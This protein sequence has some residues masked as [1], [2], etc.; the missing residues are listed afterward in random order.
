MRSGNELPSSWVHVPLGE[1][2]DWYGGGTPSKANDKFW[3]HGT[4]P[5]FSPKDMKA[6]RLQSSEDR[7]TR[8]A[9]DSSSVDVFPPDTVLMVVRSGILAHTFP[10]A[11]AGV[12]ATMNQDLKGVV[13]KGGIDATYLA[14]ALRSSG[15][16]ILNQCS[17]A[18]TT[19]ASIDTTA[20]H[21]Y[22]IPLAPTN[23]Q[24]RVV[25]KL[26]ELL[27]DLDAGI[28]AL[29]RARANLKRYRAT[30]LKA[31]VEG[32]LTEK[33]RAAHPHAEPAEKLLERILSER[34]KKWEEGQLKKYA[35]KGK[36]LPKKWRDEYVHPERSIKPGLPPLPNNWTYCS[37]A[38]LLP[39]NRSGTR[40]G[41]FGTLLGKHEHQKS[42]VP[43]VGIENISSMQFVAGSKIHISQE[44]AD[45][46]KDYEL[47]SDDVVISRSGTVGEVCVIP[48]GLGEARMSTNLM[49][50]RLVAEGMRPMWFCAL[51]AG[52]PAVATQVHELCSG[53]TR[54]FLNTEI[55]MSIVF[56]LP[57]LDEQDEILRQLES[58]RAGLDR[59]EN[60]FRRMEIVGTRL[61]QA[62]LKRAFEGK[63]V[64]QDPKDE[65]AS[66]LLARIRKAREGEGPPKRNGRRVA[67]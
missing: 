62:I 31:A 63:L 37:L 49:R 40:T 60:E 28:A 26:D 6:F 19:V 18:G 64:L 29:E 61:R 43:V 21:R 11:V 1:V 54:D 27:S 3:S 7:I 4:I 52:S 30:V 39:P 48:D 17:K 66:E 12:E 24:Q 16:D 65:P 15:R 32:R 55:L 42:G 47:V 57:P 20:L 67:V 56:P 53:S 9:V 8:A 38:E 51:F 2:G 45:Q 13:P 14:Y 22:S 36:A 59:V 46:L 50:V 34:G 33:W 41:P 25:E 44:K 58:V 35:T 23:E 5:W 10:V